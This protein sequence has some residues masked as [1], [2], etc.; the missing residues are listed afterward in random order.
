MLARVKPAC[1]DILGK[2]DGLIARKVNSSLIDNEDVAVQP[3]AV[4]GLFFRESDERA[5]DECES[6]DLG[7]LL[8]VDLAAEVAAGSYWVDLV[9]WT[10]GMEEG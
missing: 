10:V 1:V 7:E 3:E 2:S 5:L 4:H 6:E 9:W 8:L